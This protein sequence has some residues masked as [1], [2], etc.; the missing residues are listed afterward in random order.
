MSIT[1]E[2]P[3]MVIATTFKARRVFGVTLPKESAI[4]SGLKDGKRIRIEV[5]RIKDD[6]KPPEV[7]EDSKLNAS[8]SDGELMDEGRPA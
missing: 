7:L 4:C 3:V 8:T 5:Y 1:V 6:S 2:R